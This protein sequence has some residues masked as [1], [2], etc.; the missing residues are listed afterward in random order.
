M[1]NILLVDDDDQMRYTVKQMLSVDKHQV[2]EAADGQQALAL[3][4]QHPVDLVVTDICMPVM[5]GTEFILKLRERSPTMPVIAIS[6][7]QR[8]LKSNFALG[9][10]R[11]AG[12]DQ[13]LQKP[14]SLAALREAVKTA[15]SASTDSE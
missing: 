15:L 1:A 8:A 11:M 2:V 6:G 5:D 3:S 14:F 9:S 7:G 10:A 4:D 13:S 12:A